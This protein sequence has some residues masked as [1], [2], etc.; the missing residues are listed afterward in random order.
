[1]DDQKDIGF[2]KDPD[3][4]VSSNN[5]FKEPLGEK[6]AKKFSEVFNASLKDQDK[7]MSELYK[8]SQEDPTLTEKQKK[9]IAGCTLAYNSA[10]AEK[11]VSAPIISFVD[12]K[13]PNL[14]KAVTGKGYKRYKRTVEDLYQFGQ[15]T[16]FW[17]H[18]AELPQLLKAAEM[19]F[20]FRK[21]EDANK[22]QQEILGDYEYE[23][24]YV[25]AISKFARVLPLTD[26]IAQWYIVM[27]CKQISLLSF[28]HPDVIKENPGINEQAKNLM[29]AVNYIH[30]LEVQ[31]DKI[32]KKEI[33]EAEIKQ[34]EQDY[35][36]LIDHNAEKVFQ[37]N[38][39]VSEEPINPNPSIYDSQKLPDNV[40]EVEV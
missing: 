11:S 7:L 5:M 26:Y 31:R 16:G 24:M 17:I 39:T 27:L 9:I 38:V 8:E 4:Q 2:Q 13:K 29:K 23:V 25:A 20:G 33:T 40:E 14:T 19:T 10:Q 6:Y 37:N 1:M 32:S 36:E 34:E 18:V 21:K 12:N 3:P 35:E 22:S 15:R 30:F 28:V